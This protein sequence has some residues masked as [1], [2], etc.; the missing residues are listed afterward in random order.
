MGVRSA[1]QL[2]TNAAF[3]RCIFDWTC[4]SRTWIP[5]AR[6]HFGLGECLGNP[7]HKLYVR[8]LNHVVEK[9]CPMSFID[10]SRVK[11]VF[12][13]QNATALGLDARTFPAFA[14]QPRKRSRIIT[15]AQAENPVSTA[16]Q[17]VSVATMVQD[18]FFMIDIEVNS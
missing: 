7:C 6:G 2:T 11:A 1:S 13:L 3:I 8:S 4:S 16:P 10:P 15:P 17:I 14:H 12:A 5:H 9:A 18:Q